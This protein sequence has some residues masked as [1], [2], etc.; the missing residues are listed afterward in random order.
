MLAAKAFEV[1]LFCGYNVLCIAMS[2]SGMLG[3]TTHRAANI[4]LISGVAGDLP[5]PPPAASE[6]AQQSFT[7]AYKSPPFQRGWLVLDCFEL[8]CSGHSGSIL[9]FDYSPPDKRFT[10]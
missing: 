4:I 5:P 8:T 10:R 1:K 3:R 6:N 7:N 2:A 9:P